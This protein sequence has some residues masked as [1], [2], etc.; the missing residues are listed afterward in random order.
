MKEYELSVYFT[1]WGNKD[2]EEVISELEEY[3]EREYKRVHVAI[4]NVYQE[5]GDDA[6]EY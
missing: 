1:D 5:S 3:L 2:E 6:E 4:D